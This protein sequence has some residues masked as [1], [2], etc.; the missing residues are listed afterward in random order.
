MFSLWAALKSWLSGD[1]FN[2]KYQQKE[3]ELLL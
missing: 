1:C 2:S 3:K